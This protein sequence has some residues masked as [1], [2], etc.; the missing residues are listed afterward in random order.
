L[1]ER[2]EQRLLLFCRN[3]DAGINDSEVVRVLWTGGEFHAA[4]FDLG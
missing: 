4:G 3:A 1:L 2:L